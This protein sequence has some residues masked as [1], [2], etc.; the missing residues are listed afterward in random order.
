MA[1][2]AGRGTVV[3]MVARG[4][5]TLV[6]AGL[7][8]GVPLAFLMFRGTLNM[9]NLFNAELGFAYP[10]ALSLALITVAVAATFIPARRAS[11]VAPV[12]ALKE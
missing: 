10:I 9:L 3:R 1:L 5:L 12:A 4:G 2:G 11:A 6:G 7:V 8:A